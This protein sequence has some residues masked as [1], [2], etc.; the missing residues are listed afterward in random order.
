MISKSVCYFKVSVNL[1]FTH[2]KLWVYNIS[3]DA[4]N[5]TSLPKNPVRLQRFRHLL[6]LFVPWH[7]YDLNIFVSGITHSFASARQDFA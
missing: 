1:V 7:I 6:S 5:D 3:S 4:V 2:L